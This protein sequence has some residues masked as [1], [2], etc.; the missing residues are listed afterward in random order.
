MRRILTL[1]ALIVYC[2]SSAQTTEDVA[3]ELTA[4]TQVSPPSITLH[5]KPVA[6]GTPPYSVWRKSKTATAWPS[7][8][9]ATL[10]A[11]DSAFTDNAVIVDSAYEYRV[12]GLGTSFTSTGYI[13]A[14]IHC[15]AIHDRGALILIVD[16]TFSDSCSQAITKL[17]N[18]L[19]GDGWQVIRHDFDRSRLDTFI[20]AR[21]SADYATH[22]NVRAVLLLG[23]VAVPYSGDLN[24][25]GHPDHLGAWPADVFY[26][27]LTGTWTDVSVNDAGAGYIANHNTPA[28]GKWDQTALPSMNQLQVGRIDF[29]NM[30]AF[31][32]TEIQMMNGYL[33]KDH[34]YKMDSLPVAHRGL[35]DDHFGY[36]SGEAFAGNGFRNFPPLIG[37]DSMKIMPFVA[38]LASASY[39][40]AYA[41]GGGNFSGA[42][43]VGSTTDFVAN[44]VNG[45]FTMLFG[46]YFGDWNTQ[47]N[48]LRAPLCANP[49]ALT[50]CWAGRPNWFFHHMALG[51]NIGYSALLTQNNTSGLYATP[52]NYGT[53]WVH[54]ALMG[55]LSLRT[56][57]IKPPLSLAITTPFHS[58]ANLNWTAS[59]DAG[60]IGYYVYRADSQYGYYQR[61]NNSPV[62]ATTYHDVTATL[63]LKYYMV[64]PVKL[65]STPSGGYYNLG[66]GITDTATITFSVAQVTKAASNITFSVFPNPAVSYLRASINTSEQEIAVMYVVDGLGRISA[67]ATKQLNTGAN[68]YNLNVASYAPGNYTLIIEIGESRYSQKW[69]KL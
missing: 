68:T 50:S 30:P 54:A 52:L 6:Y 16:S 57:Y 29:N 21:I 26:G 58:G 65:Q 5:W 41:C 66:I 33:L 63:G 25:D 9:L 20:K 53:G 1:I 56:D 60:V 47:N 43:G 14:G 11:T 35:V 38:T 39:Q 34:A 24:P 28:D 18:D 48:F 46:S 40:W 62:T 49:P 22:P 3:V 7:T 42:S 32:S 31:S 55:D 12:Y 23:H 51:D 19:S 37:R 59:P 69:T 10:T 8:A 13:Y 2:S 44:P 17:M 36:F 45:I 4:T 61:L 15:P 64:R 67:M 27:N